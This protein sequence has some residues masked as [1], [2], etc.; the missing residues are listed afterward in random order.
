MIAPNGKI[1]SPLVKEGNSR[2]KELKIATQT[3][4]EEW[5]TGASKENLRNFGFGKYPP[6]QE[7]CKNLPEAHLAIS[8]SDPGMNSEH[9]KGI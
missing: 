8:G 1:Q 6:K 4:D 2:T 5:V 9:P 7:P 3:E